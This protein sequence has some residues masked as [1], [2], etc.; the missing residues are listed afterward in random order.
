M[1][2]VGIQARD[3]RGRTSGSRVSLTFVIDTSGSMDMENR[4]ELVKAALDLLV[5]RLNAND[6]VAIVTF[7]RLTR[8]RRPQRRLP[9]PSRRPS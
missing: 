8:I 4:L 6:S 3:D 7:W 5:S 9:P 1:L 2:R